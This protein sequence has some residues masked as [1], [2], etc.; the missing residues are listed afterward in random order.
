MNYL[1]KEKEQE[2][3]EKLLEQD[4]EDDDPDFR[5]YGFLKWTK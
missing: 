3:L 5:Q 1:D 2:E 4:K